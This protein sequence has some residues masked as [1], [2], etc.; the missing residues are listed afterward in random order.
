MVR[1]AG[2]NKVGIIQIEYF[3]IS[4]FIGIRPRNL[5][6]NKYRLMSSPGIP[7]YF[8][9]ISFQCRSCSRMIGC[10]VTSVV[11]FK[12]HTDDPVSIFVKFI[13][14]HFKPD[15]LENGKA[16]GH[17]NCKSKDINC[18]KNFIPEQVSD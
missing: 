8:R 3:R 1:N 2:I 18:G 5:I 6:C 4:L 15:I 16:C 10:T 13:I 12:N 17:S 14:A 11:H 9:K 7:D